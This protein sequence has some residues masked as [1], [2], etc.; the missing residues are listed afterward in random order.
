MTVEDARSFFEAHPKIRRVAE[1]LYQV[2]LGYLELGQTSTTLSGGE[3][4][5]VKLATELSKGAGTL[6]A[7]QQH[8]LYVLDEPTTGL[9]FED[10]RKLVAVL[11]Q[12]VDQGN[13]VVVIEHNLDV[14]KCADWIIDMGPEGGDGG[15]TVVAE[16]PPEKRIAKVAKSH[17]GHY[18]KGPLVVMPLGRL[19]AR[20]LLL[21]DRRVFR[22][23][24]SRPGRGGSGIP[25]RVR[26]RAS[27]CR[28]RSCSVR[29]D[30]DV[31]AFRDFKK[32]HVQNV[33]DRLA[34]ILARRNKIRVEVLNEDGRAAKVHARFVRVD[35]RRRIPK[36]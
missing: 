17:T 32:E 36:S 19:P 34:R 24:R 12:L 35:R 21:D 3:A 31:R 7:A 8:T 23:L 6:R 18:L 25:D 1:A 9:H 15:G 11:E 29:A 26:A 28:L 10:V 4:Q 14:I 22:G 27:T 5:R 33:E 20:F 13:T 2:G 16:G 30:R